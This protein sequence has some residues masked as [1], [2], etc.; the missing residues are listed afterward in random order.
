MDHLLW[1]R[2]SFHTFSGVDVGMATN[3]LLRIRNLLPTQP[4]LV[5]KVI[6]QDAATDTSVIELPTNQVTTAYDPAVQAGARFVARGRIVL[7]GSNAF[8]RAGVVES[9][10]PDQAVTEIEIGRVV[11]I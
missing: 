11:S 5:G 1:A 10:A 3:P 6:S 4:V 7:V 2:L 8:V 9:Q